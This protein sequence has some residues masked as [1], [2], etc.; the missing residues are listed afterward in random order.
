MKLISL[1]LKERFRNLQEGFEINFHNPDLES[2]PTINLAEFHPFCLAGLNGSGKSNVLEVL[3]SIFYHLECC[4][5]NYPNYAF[6]ANVSNPDSFELEYFIAKDSISQKHED[7]FKVKITKTVSYEPRMQVQEYPFTI[8]WNGVKPFVI[9]NER[10]ISYLPDLIVAYSSG[11]NEILSLPFIKM[12]LFQYDEYIKDSIKNSIYEK[13]KSRLLYIDYEMSQ[14]VLLTILLFFQNENSV[15]TIDILQPIVKELGIDKMVSFSIN[16]NNYWQKLIN[17]NLDEIEVETIF[18]Y[19]NE[20]KSEDKEDN[21]RKS[22]QILTHLEK[23]IEKL[24]KCATC[25]FESSEYIK[26]DFWVNGETTKAVKDIF[27]ND[28]YEFFS[29]FQ[30]LQILNERV[31]KIK[32]KREIYESKGFYT[33]YKK[34]EHPWFFYFTDYFI[35]K[36]NKGETK[37]R[38]LLLKNLSDGEQQFLHTL[39]ICLMLQNK[40]ALLL[41]DEPETHFNPDWRSKFINILRKTLIAGNDNFLLKDIVLTSHSPFIIS[42]CLPDKVIIFEKNNE[43]DG[44]VICKN[45]KESEFNTYGTSIDIIT[46]KI[47]KNVNTIGDYSRSELQKIDFTQIKSLK[48]VEKAKMQI[49]QLGDS[50]EKDWTLIRLN[51]MKF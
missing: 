50:I 16:L 20:D 47:F 41:L 29:V 6:D 13:P 37:S 48:D 39:G 2:Y 15:S 26:L 9:S 40:R 7:L 33:D 42:D 10:G 18:N 46:E 14:A 21:K 30:M 4:V 27:N 12:R 32:E 38:Q 43:T 24:K 1:K 51:N 31:E 25:Y 36:T 22:W 17:E 34:T 44:M 28:P 5:H 49:S 11:E 3:A 35:N 19:T 45:A 23:Q 8:P